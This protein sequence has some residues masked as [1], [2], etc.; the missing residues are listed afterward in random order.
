M[1][2][3]LREAGDLIDARQ[4]VDHAGVLSNFSSQWVMTRPAP[5]G[6][7]FMTALP[8]QFNKRQFRSKDGAFFKGN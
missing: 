4:L 7:E 6:S 5:S 3:C 1:V 2:A 8:V